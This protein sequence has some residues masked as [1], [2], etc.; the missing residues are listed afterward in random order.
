MA[1]PKKKTP[2]KKPRKAP[3]KKA[4]PKKKQTRSTRKM[5]AAIFEK[6]CV[7]IEGTHEGLKTICSKFNTSSS[8]FFDLLDGCDDQKLSDRYARARKRQ[9][10][11][12]FDLGRETV[13]NREND[14]K[15]FVGANHIQRDKLIHDSIKWQASKLDSKK[16]GDKVDVN[17][18]G[19]IDIDWSE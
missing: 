2:A 7:E 14:E 3:V 10:E 5:T 9:A 16:Y 4:A 18:S 17:H 15:P 19:N 8:A 6:V 13:F 11:Y 1:V 12:L